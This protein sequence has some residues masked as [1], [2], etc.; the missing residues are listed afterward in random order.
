LMLEMEL[1][2]EMAAMDKEIKDAV[3]AQKSAQMASGNGANA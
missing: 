3:I 1:K 2:R